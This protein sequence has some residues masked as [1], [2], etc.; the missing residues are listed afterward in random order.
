MDS[1]YQ[2]EVNGQPIIV[3]HPGIS[4][5]HRIYDNRAQILEDLI[6]TTP[7]AESKWFAAAKELKDFEL[8]MRLAYKSPCD[9]RTL[10]KASSDFKDIN[11][12]FAAE[13]GLAAIHWLIK[14]HGLNIERYDIQLALS[15][16]MAA[17]KLV[18]Q[19]A[20][21]IKLIDEMLLGKSKSSNVYQVL[22]AQLA[23]RR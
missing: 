14:G 15:H 22:T 18:G 6:A 12:V 4:G 11:P 1:V 16:T 21:A 9:P 13:V 17:A 7:G 3:C 10:T 19:E 8:A 20:Q 2:L 23:W 5:P